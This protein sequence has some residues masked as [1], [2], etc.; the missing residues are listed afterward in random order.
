MASESGLVRP[1]GARIGGGQVG[2]RARS[3]HAAARTAHAMR[4]CPAGSL[5]PLLSATVLRDGIGHDANGSTLGNAH[6][7]GCVRMDTETWALRPSGR[8]G[9]VAGWRTLG[10]L[11]RCGV[12]ASSSP[13]CSVTTPA[14]R[15]S[16]WTRT[17]GSTSG[18]SSRGWP[19]PACRSRR[20]SSSASWRRT[21]SHATPLRTGGFGRT[22]DTRSRSIS[23][24]P[25]S[26]RHRS[27]STE[28]H[29]GSSNP[30]SR[31]GSTRATGNMCTSP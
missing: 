21:P 31:P 2:G 20:P 18:S 4:W 12:R 29:A 9:R 10:G 27:S 22:R 5:P 19:L 7:A 28:P 23:D 13:W 17:A 16:T 6:P 11:I 8:R 24:S 15:E 26:R 3:A 30:S 25:R 1:H 14:P